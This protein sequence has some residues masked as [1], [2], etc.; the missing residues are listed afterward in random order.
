M[1][2]LKWGVLFLI[3]GIVIVAFS[4]IRSK[5]NSETSVNGIVVDAKTNNPIVGADVIL[6]KWYKDGLFDTSLEKYNCKTNNKGEYSF[7]ISNFEYIQIGAISDSYYPDKSLIKES[8]QLKEKKIIKL[9]RY[10]ANPNLTTVVDDN[11]VKDE[12]IY[13]RLSSRFYYKNDIIVKKESKGYSFSKMTIT[14]N[15]ND[16]DIWIECRDNE[17]KNFTFNTRNGNLISTVKGNEIKT[18]AFIEFDQLKSCNEESH[19]I[20]K[21]DEIFF[22]KCINGV[23]AKLIRLGLLSYNDI[24]NPNRA[25]NSDYDYIKEVEFSFH[26]LLLKNGETNFA[27]FPNIGLSDYLINIEYR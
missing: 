19:L 8:H 12:N 3:I 27:Y 5:F 17:H 2:K 13:P 11:K 24:P 14:D 18:N 1:K 25:I 6:V 23:N 20:Q 9:N 7:T 22:V 16:F 26:L 21:D 4:K 15:V 10:T